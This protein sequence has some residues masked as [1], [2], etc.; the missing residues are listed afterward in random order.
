MWPVLQ[1]RSGKKWC[2]KLPENRE[3]LFVVIVL[4]CKHEKPIIHIGCNVAKNDGNLSVSGKARDQKLALVLN[5][6]LLLMVPWKHQDEGMLLDGL[7][8]PDALKST[9][10]ALILIVAAP[11]IGVSILIRLVPNYPDI[12]LTGGFV[13]FILRMVMEHDDLDD[14]LNSLEEAYV[15]DFLRFGSKHPSWGTIA[16]RFHLYWWSLIIFTKKGIAMSPAGKLVRSVA[17]KWGF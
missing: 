6:L 17:K 5:K 14:Q 15:I 4:G 8:G 9:V 7:P 10:G 2:A 11:V 13:E 1:I 3:S 16:A 12:N